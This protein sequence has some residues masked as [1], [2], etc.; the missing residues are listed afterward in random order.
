MAIDGINNDFAREA[1]TNISTL[2]E[3]YRLERETLCLE[4]K[5]AHPHRMETYVGIL[6]I[7]LVV[8][9]CELAVIGT[10]GILVKMFLGA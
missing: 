10:L 3:V 6:A 1:Y 2:H 7:T 5:F 8:C 9:V 4:D